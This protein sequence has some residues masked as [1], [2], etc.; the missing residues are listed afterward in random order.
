MNSSYW[1]TLVTM[2]AFVAVGIPIVAFLWETLHEVLTFHASVWKLAAAVPVLGILGLLL[3]MAGTVYRD[4][5]G[6]AG[7]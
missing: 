6:S 4:E 2:L 7:L 5:L 1:R 3:R